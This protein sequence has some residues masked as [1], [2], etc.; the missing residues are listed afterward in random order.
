MIFFGYLLCV[1]KALREQNSLLASEALRSRELPLSYGFSSLLDPA[2]Q[3][4]QA[5][6]TSLLFQG[7]DSEGLSR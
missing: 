2:S 3:V 7:N 1:N 6:A 5:D 4:S